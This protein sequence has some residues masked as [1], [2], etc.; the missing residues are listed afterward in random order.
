MSSVA[1]SRGRGDEIQLLLSWKTRLLKNH[2]TGVMGI[3][4]FAGRRNLLR[5]CL[6]LGQRLRACAVLECAVLECALLPYAILIQAGELQDAM[7]LLLLALVL[8]AL[9]ALAL[10]LLVAAVRV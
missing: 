1:S 2:R 7:A 3:F 9:L 10:L 5:R 4:L 8:L 6:L